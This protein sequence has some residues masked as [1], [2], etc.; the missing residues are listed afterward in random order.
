[1]SLKPAWT[2]EKPY[3]KERKKKL[4]KKRNSGGDIFT[5]IPKKE[6]HRQQPGCLLDTLLSLPVLDNAEVLQ[7]DTYIGNSHNSTSPLEGAP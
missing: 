4:V 2:M 6:K 7:C 1:M 5:D 3:L